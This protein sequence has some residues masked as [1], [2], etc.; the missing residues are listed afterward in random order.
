MRQGGLIL[1]AGR[2]RSKEEKNRKNNTK[3]S[4]PPKAHYE[5]HSSPATATTSRR[6]ATKHVPRVSPY[7]PASIDPELVEIG[8]VQLSQ[9]VNTTTVRHTLTD[10]Q[11]DRRTDRLIKY[12]HPVRTPVC[13]GFYSYSQKPASVASLSRLCLIKNSPNPKHTTKSTAVRPPRPTRDCGR[14]NTSHAVAHTR[15]LPP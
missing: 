3:K 6:R 4:A 8:L 9:S 11:T 7:S 10:I 2:L 13:R 14:Q 1:S 5:I 12:W 15:T